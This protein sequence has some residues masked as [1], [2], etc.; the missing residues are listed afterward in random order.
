MCQAVAE[1]MAEEPFISIIEKNAIMQMAFALLGSKVT[2]KLFEEK[3][4][5]GDEKNGRSN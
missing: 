3:I 5:K 4:T 2:A 1:T